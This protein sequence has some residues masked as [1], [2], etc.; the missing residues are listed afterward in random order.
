MSVVDS[1]NPRQVAAVQAASTPSALL[2]QLDQHLI[3]ASVGGMP[4]RQFAIHDRWIVHAFARREAI[5]ILRI[6]A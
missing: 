2:I 1:M 4:R 3:E 5:S 6:H